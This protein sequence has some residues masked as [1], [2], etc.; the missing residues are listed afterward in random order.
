M[1]TQGTFLSLIVATGA[2]VFS[3]AFAQELT[4]PPPAS[5]ATP[6]PITPARG[7]SMDDV[8]AKFGAPSQEVPSIGQPPITRWDYP[9]YVVFFEHDKVL[10]TVVVRS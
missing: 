6:A 2:L 8:K 4:T 10:H 1:R 5:T 3:S 7:S 9:G